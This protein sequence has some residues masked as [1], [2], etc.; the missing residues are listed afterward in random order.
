MPTTITSKALIATTTLHEALAGPRGAASLAVGERQ[1]C[2]G[3]PA[4][5]R[6]PRPR[7]EG[8]S[9][10]DRAN[11]ILHG[12]PFVPH[13]GVDDAV[14]KFVVHGEAMEGPRDPDLSTGPAADLGGV[15]ENCT[16]RRPSRKDENVDGALIDEHGDLVP[17][18]LHKPDVGAYG[19]ATAR[20]CPRWTTPCTQKSA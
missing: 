12:A 2:F 14:V 5:C 17:E 13:A 9:P 4:C 20:R 15:V 7:S 11:I 16:R 10:P 8:P 19:S 6:P 1:S 3:L 18:D